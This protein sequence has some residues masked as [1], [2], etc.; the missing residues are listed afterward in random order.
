MEATNHLKIRQALDEIP[1]YVTDFVMNL[2]IPIHVMG[3]NHIRTAIALAVEDPTLT[4]QVTKVLY[5][6][7]AEKYCTTSTRVE[8]NIRHA[9]EKSFERV[10]YQKSYEALGYTVNPLKCKLTNSEFIALAATKI[11]SQLVSSE[12]N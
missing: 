2:G 11:R 9:I 1:E 5:P 10:D 7:V 3:F 4:K 8:R 6:M 12:S